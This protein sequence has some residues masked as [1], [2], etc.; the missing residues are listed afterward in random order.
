[1]QNDDHFY[2]VER[3][4]YELKINRAYNLPTTDNTFSEI[5]SENKS[6]MYSYNT[7]PVASIY[8]DD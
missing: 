8:D 1:M 7:I 4:L 5:I 6:S 2:E 3:K